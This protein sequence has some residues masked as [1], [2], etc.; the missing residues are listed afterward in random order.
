MVSRIDQGFGLD[1][2][3]THIGVTVLSRRVQR[4]PFPK[5]KGRI[6]AL[7]TKPESRPHLQMRK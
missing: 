3:P 7:K 2:K 5:T 6:Q 4:R 1:E